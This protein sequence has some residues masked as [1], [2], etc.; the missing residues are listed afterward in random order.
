MNDDNYEYIEL[1]N[2]ADSSVNL[3]GF[4][5]V[6]GIEFIFPQGTFINPGE[7]IVLLKNSESYSH[8]D[9][10]RFQW[11][12]GNLADRVLLVLKKSTLLNGVVE[13]VDVSL[14]KLPVSAALKKT[15]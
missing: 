9:C 6:N 2:I 7:Y 14:Q 1:C 12:A 15:W 10:Q 11:N 4:S 8:L 3:S 5:F 13:R